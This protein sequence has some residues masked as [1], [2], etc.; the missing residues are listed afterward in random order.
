MNL[1]ALFPMN[2]IVMFFYRLSQMV[3]FYPQ[4]PF[5]SLYL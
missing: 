4:C 3:P 2:N 1:F 5:T